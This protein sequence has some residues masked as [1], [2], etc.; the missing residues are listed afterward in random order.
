MT[1]EGTESDPQGILE[2]VATPGFLDYIST[3]GERTRAMLERGRWH[4]WNNAS[5]RQE[6]GLRTW[7][8]DWM[9]ED[10]TWSYVDIT[11]RVISQAYNRVSFRAE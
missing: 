8:Y 4:K 10:L 3:L 5:A 11:P 2:L 1:W 7:H 6:K 9:F